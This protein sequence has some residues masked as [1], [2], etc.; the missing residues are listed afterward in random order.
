MGLA[1]SISV[2]SARHLESAAA[3][4]DGV[5][6]G[7]HGAVLEIAFQVTVTL[8]ARHPESLS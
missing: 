8:R 6:M 5:A 1:T 3:L 4:A 7:S 2:V